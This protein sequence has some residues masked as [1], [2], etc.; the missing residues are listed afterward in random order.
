MKKYILTLCFVLLTSIACLSQTANWVPA[1]KVILDILEDT[2]EDMELGL[3]A[4]GGGR[5]AVYAVEG[6]NTIEYL[7]L[8]NK[9][10]PVTSITETELKKRRGGAAEELIQQILTN[11]VD[12]T[13]EKVIDIMAAT[14]GQIRLIFAYEGGKTP[15]TKHISI[16]SEDMKRVYKS[17]AAKLNATP[18]GHT[19]VGNANGMRITLKFKDGYVEAIYSDGRR[20]SSYTYTW[21]KDGKYVIMEDEDEVPFEI[22]SNAQTL[23][24]I[25]SGVVFRLKK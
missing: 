14:D 4:M 17:M 23:T 13:V 11:Y 7:T 6:E 16:T 10:T 3:S 8:F 2:L 15:V 22:S 19:Y 5:A 12:G 24:D 18:Q 21:Y 1:A 9:S 20:E 25:A